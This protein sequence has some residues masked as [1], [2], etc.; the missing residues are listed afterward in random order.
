MNDLSHTPLS[1]LSIGL[2]EFIDEFGDELLDSLNRSNPPVYAGHINPVAFLILQQAPAVWT[3]GKVMVT[4]RTARP[5]HRAPV[6]PHP[7]AHAPEDEELLPPVVRLFQLVAQ[8]EQLDQAVRSIEY[9]DACVWDG[10]ENLSPPLVDQVWRRND[11]GAAIA[12]FVHDGG[13]SDGHHGL[14][15]AHLC[16]DHCSL[17]VTIQQ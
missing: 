16:V 3:T 11:Q 17:L 13:Y 1:P 15:S 10:F 5:T 2:T 14:A 12:G 7:H 6:K 8:L 9:P 4:N